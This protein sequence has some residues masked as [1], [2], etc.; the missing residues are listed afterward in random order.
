MEGARLKVKVHY[1]YRVPTGGLHVRLT[2]LDGA[3]FHIH[4]DT[5]IGRAADAAGAPLI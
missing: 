2:E 1:F 4:T 3:A 5:E